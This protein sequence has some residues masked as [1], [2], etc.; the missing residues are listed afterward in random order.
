M[1]LLCSFKDT[2]DPWRDRRHGECQ[3][4]ANL[5]LL[6][7]I[8]SVDGSVLFKVLGNVRV[9]F[10]QYNLP[11][12]VSEARAW[13]EV[14]KSFC[15]QAE[16]IAFRN[17]LSNQD[18]L[19]LSEEELFLGTSN[20]ANK[21]ERSE[22]E[23]LFRA[24]TEMSENV[25]RLRREIK[26][27]NP[28]DILDSDEDDDQDGVGDADQGSDSDW[29]DSP[30]GNSVWSQASRDESPPLVANTISSVE[31]VKR[32]YSAAYYALDVLL[33]NEYAPYGTRLYAFVCVDLL[34]STIRNNGLWQEY[35]PSGLKQGPHSP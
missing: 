26:Y 22:Y 32:A 17:C 15:G 6:D 19:K 1:I 29:T 27:P 14:F 18:H 4:H 25:Q 20:I 7:E 10:Q 30:V 3:L 21:I 31:V 28:N 33:D 11:K 12:Y 24:R 13:E 5:H 8:L 9:S 16:K 2:P 35:S 34:L 23:L